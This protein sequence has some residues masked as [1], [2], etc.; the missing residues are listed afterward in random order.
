MKNKN[1][2]V[3][4]I[5]VIAAMVL[6]FTVFAFT[7][8]VYA[9][10]Q[11]LQSKSSNELTA[12][13]YA[14]KIMEEIKSPDVASVTDQGWEKI[15]DTYFFSKIEKIEAAKT[16][17]CIL[18]TVKVTVFGKCPDPSDLNDSKKAGRLLAMGSAKVELVTRIV[19]GYLK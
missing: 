12:L 16:G 15:P 5:D 18:Y 1:K 10:I 9:G 3:F 11:K 14:R 2:G 7:L 13:S 4:L 6:L 19:K 8:G 17:S